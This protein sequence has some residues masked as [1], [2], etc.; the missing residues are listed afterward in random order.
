[1]FEPRRKLNAVASD[2]DEGILPYEPQ[3][4]LQPAQTVNYYR[5]VDDVAA[6]HVGVRCVLYQVYR[7]P[8][9]HIYESAE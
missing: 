7:V 1:M 9:E 5:T 8:M 6:F 4:R 3:I 2:R